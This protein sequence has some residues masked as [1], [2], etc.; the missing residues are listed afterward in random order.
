MSY[1]RFTQE[2]NRPRFGLFFVI[3]HRDKHN[4]DTSLRAR[5]PCNTL[6]PGIL[7]LICVL[8]KLLLPFSNS[9]YL[10]R[11]LRN[12]FTYANKSYNFTFYQMQLV[13]CHLSYI[14]SWYNIFSFHFSITASSLICNLFY[15]GMYLISERT[16]NPMLV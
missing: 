13:S 2:G 5:L 3:S 4:T 7:N 6:N 16:C 11:I 9:S 14:S 12:H 10:G 15:Y 1:M 8:T